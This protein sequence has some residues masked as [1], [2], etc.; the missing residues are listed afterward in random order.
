[1]NLL[2]FNTEGHLLNNDGT[3][4]R[5]EES[6]GK[7]L[8]HNTLR[9]IEGWT[10][11]QSEKTGRRVLRSFFVY[12]NKCIRHGDAGFFPSRVSDPV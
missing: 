10:H 5:Y 12:N 3:T 6:Y 2:F 7:K 11:G 8:F 4:N 1:M 9:C